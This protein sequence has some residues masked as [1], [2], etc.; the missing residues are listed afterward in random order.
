MGNHLADISARNTALKGTNNSQTSVMVQ[1][2]SFPNENLE[3][4][5]KEAK[6]NWTQ[7]RKSR[8]GNSIILG[9][10]KRESSGLDQI[11]TQS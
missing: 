5:F 11:I 1:R 4:L 9:F 10:I 2:D 3:N 7:K 8:I 6:H